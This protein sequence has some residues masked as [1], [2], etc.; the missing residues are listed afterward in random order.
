MLSTINDSATSPNLGSYTYALYQGTSMATPHVAGIASLMLSRSPALTPSQVLALIQTTARA[1]PTNTTFNCTTAT[2]GAGIID[3]AAA[4]IAAGGG[5]STTTTALTSAPNPAIVG[6]SVTFTAT[7]AG[8]NP[9][10]SVSFAADGGAP[11]T[12]CNAVALSGTGNSRTASCLS[13]SL[14]IGTH[15][16]VASY[17]GDGANAASVSPALAQV[18]TDAAGNSNVALASAGAIA[19]A[20]S[21]FKATYPA[22]AVNN[23]ERAGLNI[24]NGGVWADATANAYPDWV[25][26]NFSGSK[27][28]S[29]VVVYSVQD[30][31]ANPIEPTDTQTFSLYG[32]TALTVEG[33]N[34]ST[35]TWATLATVS[36]NNLVKRS[37]TFPAFITDRIRVNVTNA[38][39]SYSRITEI[40]AWGTAVASVSNVALA[41]AGAIASASTT[42]KA[43]YPAT[44]VNNNERAGL[45][46]GNGG[47]WADATANAYPDWVQINFSGSKTISR[48]VVYSV[49]DNYANPI[50]PTDTQTFSLYG[51][52][53]LTVDGWNASTSTW[54][55]LA[56]VSGNNLVKR[57]LTFPAFTTDRIRV[58]VTNALASYSRITEIEAW[59]T[60]VAGLLPTT[61]AL[62]SAPN[63]ALVG[64][65]VTFTATVAGSN[66]TGS[67]S[68]AADGGAPLTGCNAVAL[69]G[70]GNSR[71]ASCLSSSLTIGTHSMVAS[72]SGDGANAASVS[73]ALAQ[74]ITAR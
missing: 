15:S 24:G 9:T 68:F 12:G 42:F 23:N 19:S 46:L 14:T 62:T 26:I 18:I 2:C 56:T 63:P 49:Q 13:S 65:S 11:L 30:N 73:P 31:Y 41:S 3:A 32:V 28:I 70:T 66:P 33:W 52:T 6:A 17:S 55:T 38:L 5:Q 53:A 4:V 54:A 71:T 1:F 64:A 67:V 47:V 48:V 69:S 27:T 60:A 72:Y 7:V 21:T 34:A 40:E 59:G 20:S 51:V 35:S 10:G 43:T 74:V 25:Q 45:N 58:N 50:E 29:R 36:G 39:A 44:A 37:L 8:S 61:T 57:S 16:M 22:T